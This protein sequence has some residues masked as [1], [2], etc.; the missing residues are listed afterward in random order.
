MSLRISLVS[1][2][3]VLFL[4]LSNPGFAQEYDIQLLGILGKK[5]V[6]NVD[7]QRRLVAT[8]KTTSEGIL[9]KE[10]RQES[11]VL[12]INGE[13]KEI[14]LGAR[15]GGKYAKRESSKATIYAD[16]DG[17][18]MTIGRINGFPVNMLLD[19]GATSVAM[20][21]SSAKRMGIN[22][23]VDGKKIPVSTASGNAEGYLVQLRS[24]SVGDIT[25]NNIEAIVIDGE[26]PSIPLLGMSFLRQLQVSTEGRTMVLQTK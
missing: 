22:Y 14:E 8:G 3:A 11:A 23:R 7:G 24:V 18:Y 12:L 1:F 2:F 21:D 17:M 6:L 15:I 25:L 4:F 9:L 16:S 13:L 26:G 5:A 20:D 19:T 10:L